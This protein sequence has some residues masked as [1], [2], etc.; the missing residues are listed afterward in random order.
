M[1]NKEVYNIILNYNIL[2]IFN[3]PS[4]Y[5]KN[6]LINL[7][8][9]KNIFG[10]FFTIKRSKFQLIPEIP[11]NVHGCIGKYNL[12]F[13]ELSSNDIFDN[14]ESIAKSA[15]LND[16]RGFLFNKKFGS[17]LF[18]S[19]AEIE[20][21]LMKLPIYD[22]DQK[23]GILSNHINLPFFNNKN[24]GIIVMNE[25]NSKTATFLPEVFD[26]KTKWID[27]KKDI[28]EK[29]NIYE[30]EKVYFKAYQIEKYS[31]KIINILEPNYIN[32]IFEKIGGFFNNYYNSIIPYAIVKNQDNNY[33]I[34]SDNNDDIRNIATIKDLTN[35]NKVYNILNNNVIKQINN[36]IKEYDKKYNDD[37][38]LIRQ[39]LSFLSLVTENE[40]N[41]K[42]ISNELVNNINNMER[43]FELGQALIALVNCN[44]CDI[45]NK[46][47]K[48]MYD[49]LNTRQKIDINDLF[50]INWQTMALLSYTNNDKEHLDLLINKIL[51]ILYNVDISKL[52]TNYIAVSFECI[53]HI[54]KLDKTN[55]RLNN[56]LFYIF[57]LLQERFSIFGLYMFSD[58]TARIDITGHCINGFIQYF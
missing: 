33:I 6:D 39:A 7:I 49:E 48:E 44:K 27:I 2:N 45:V 30:D 43:D 22:I 55:N 20:I 53:S 57:A 21:S 37:N 58:N 4:F 47:L 35:M 9:N 25:D 19:E 32:T 14:I 40:E 3:I 38:I 26:S 10:T 12:S 46:S 31:K 56:T 11:H 42:K 52:E 50:R 24:Y 1:D 34:V 16:N 5:N 23:N 51:D 41:I 29:A 13:N 18:D 8:N 15:A 28:L 36:D 54:Y 17:L